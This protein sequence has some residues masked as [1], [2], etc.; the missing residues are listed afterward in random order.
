MPPDLTV[1]RLSEHVTWL[2]RIEDI[3]RDAMLYAFLK[4]VYPT[5]QT[6]NN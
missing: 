1:R 6:Q 2:N 3:D 5:E 4:K